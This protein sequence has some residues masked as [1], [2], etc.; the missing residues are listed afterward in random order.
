VAEATEHPISAIVAANGDVVS[1][2]APTEVAALI[3]ALAIDPRTAGRLVGRQP[4]QPA[5]HTHRLFLGGI[6][7]DGGL[8]VLIKLDASPWELHWMLALGDLTTGNALCRTAPPAGERILLIDPIPRVAPWAWDAAYCQALC[9]STDVRMV[10]R[11]AEFRRRHGLHAPTGAELERLAAVML[12][13]LGALWWGIAPWRREDAAWCRQIQRYD[14]GASSTPLHA[15]TD[16]PGYFPN[17]P[18]VVAAL[19]AAGTDPNAPAAACSKIEM[20]S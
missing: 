8:P 3:A 11:M 6:W 15:A 10:Q 1:R 12:A 4:T 17:G 18:A 14:K 19:L 13:W 20:D 9:S 2:S 7:S 5:P 16:W